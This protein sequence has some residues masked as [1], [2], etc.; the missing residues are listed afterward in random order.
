M[1]RNGQD[2][3][4]GELRIWLAKRNLGA[5]D[6]HNLLTAIKQF[7]PTLDIVAASSNEEAMQARIDYLED[8]KPKE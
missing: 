7:A 3:R 8:I 1:S 6:E 4:Y 2:D 5:E